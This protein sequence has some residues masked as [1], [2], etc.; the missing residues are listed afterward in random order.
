[1]PTMEEN[2]IDLRPGRSNH[3]ALKQLATLIELRCVE[4]ASLYPGISDQPRYRC[5]C[6][7]VLDVDAKIYH[8][9]KQE[10]ALQQ[11]F[12][13]LTNSESDI[14]PFMGDDWRQL[15]EERALQSLTWPINVDAQL[16]NASGVWRYRELI[17]PIPEQ[18]IVSRPEGN[19]G[20]Y[21]VGTENCGNHRAG[22]RQI[23]HYAGLDYLFLKHEGENPTG[24]F[25]DRGMTV[26]V[27]MANLL[28]ARA[29][30]CASTGNTSASLASYASQVGLPCIVFLPAIQ[31]SGAN[32]FF[33]SYMS[34]FSQREHVQAQTIATAIKIGDPVSYSRARQI[35]EESNGIVEEVT[36]E[37][38]LAAKSV[39]DRSGIGC[40]PASAA[41]LAGVY[42][43]VGSGII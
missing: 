40:E 25:K 3:S 10:P 12:E 19:T 9:F 32:P 14:K 26:G 42:K 18:Y 27:T 36:D 15:F 37:E 22:H 16:L 33:R 11:E 41:T 20:L 38:I 34:G 5:D 6:G 7:G 24:S 2:S 13:T 23:G 1:M 31:A 17:L 35:I 21:P 4:C 43:L 39:I 29:V 28:G 8:P 30:A